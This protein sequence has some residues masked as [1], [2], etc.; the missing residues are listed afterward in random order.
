MISWKP[1]L[2]RPSFAA[3]VL[4]G[5]PGAFSVGPVESSS[6]SVLANVPWISDVSIDAGPPALACDTPFL[7][8]R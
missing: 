5:F 6:S 2:P 7:S 1:G 4:Y 3:P 8:L